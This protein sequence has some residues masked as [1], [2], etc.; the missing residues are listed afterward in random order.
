MKRG[1]KNNYET[2]FAN[3]RTM[4]QRS[5]KGSTCNFNCISCDLCLPNGGYFELSRYIISIRLISVK[6]SMVVTK[7]PKLYSDH[8]FNQQLIQHSFLT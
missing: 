8:T 4:S 6:I 5:I 7:T 3:T 1:L 2:M